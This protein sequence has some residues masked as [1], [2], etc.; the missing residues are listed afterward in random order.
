M[1]FFLGIRSCPFPIEAGTVT[2]ILAPHQDD[3]TLGCGGTIALLAEAGHSVHVTFVTDG[4][5]S[6]P[7]YP[8]LVRRRKDEALQAATQLGVAHPHLEFLDAR[9]GSL[10]RLTTAE[11]GALSEKMAATLNRIR[12]TLVLLPCREDGSS[13]HDAAHALFVQALATT[14]LRPRMGEFPVWSWWNP[15]LLRR[16]LGR[17]RQVWR[18][19]FPQHLAAKKRA[20]ACYETQTR[21]LEPDA[22]PMLTPEFISFFLQSQ[23]FFFEY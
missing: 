4:A 22:G 6:Q 15:R 7:G 9:D 2:L 18:A 11:A 1:R 21:A 12:P 16:P 3:E 10:A 23:E 8:H 19:T 14:N 5:A 13:E 20:L 17:S